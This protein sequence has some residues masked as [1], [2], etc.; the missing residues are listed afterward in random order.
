[1]WVV[2]VAVGA[3]SYLLR[4]GPLLVLQRKALPA[5]FEATVRAA[6]VAAIAGLVATSGTDAAHDGRMIPTLVAMAGGIV[7][8]TRRAPMAVVLGVGGA[9]YLAA[10]LVGHALG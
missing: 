10:L 4:V 6:G 9:L 8:S 2:I 5:R 1:M 7:A 3:G